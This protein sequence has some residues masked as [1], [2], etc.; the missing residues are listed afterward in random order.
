MN[1]NIKVKNQQKKQ[2]NSIYYKENINTNTKGNYMKTVQ[3]QQQKKCQ[4][5][6]NGKIPEQRS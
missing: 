3:V 1:I 2:K 6:T 4:T 5:K